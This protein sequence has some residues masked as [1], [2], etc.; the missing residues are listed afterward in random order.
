INFAFSQVKIGDNPSVINSESVLELESTDKVLVITRVTNSQMNAIRP[1]AGGMVYNRDRQCVFQYNGNN[2]ISLCE[3]SGSTGREIK[4]TV[5]NNDGTFTI[6]YSDDTSF[7]SSDLTGPQGEVG[8][9]GPIGLT[10][11]EG[12]QGPQGEKGDQG[13]VGP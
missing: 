10:G 1:L 6:I 11:P 4:S 2:W 9:Q 7:T 12:P 13:D 5:D 8:P 3:G